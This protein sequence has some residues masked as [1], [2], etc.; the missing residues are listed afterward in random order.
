MEAFLSADTG[1]GLVRPLSLDDHL[2]AT[3]FVTAYEA[4][5]D[6]ETDVFLTEGELRTASSAGASTS[7]VTLDSVYLSELSELALESIL[8]EVPL[9]PLNLFIDVKSAELATYIAVANALDVYP[10]LEEAGFLRVIMTG[11]VPNSGTISYTP[12]PDYMDVE[13]INNN[14]SFNTSSSALATI[15]T[16]FQSISGWP[17]TFEMPISMRRRLR[18]FIVQVHNSNKDPRFTGIP[19]TDP[20]RERVWEVL[21]QERGGFIGTTDIAGLSA[22]L[23]L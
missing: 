13:G 18:N 21:L 7:G 1:D 6:I 9:P 3:P 17:G 2:Q 5:F 15:R 4:G 14:A 20:N 10:E 8:T 11:N 22:F 19:A 16:S 23:G 12:H